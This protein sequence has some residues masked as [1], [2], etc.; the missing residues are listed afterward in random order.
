[1][2]CGASIKPV[3]YGVNLHVYDLAKHGSIGRMV[4]DFT[5]LRA[6]HT[7][8]EVFRHG[9]SKPGIEYSYGPEYGVSEKPPLSNPSM[10]H[11]E[12]I[13]MG[14]CERTPLELTQL[15]FSVRARWKGADYHA[16]NHNCNHFSD[17]LVYILV[18]KHIEARL[19]KENNENKGKQEN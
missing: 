17:D 10:D 1:M 13:F 2:G 15:I 11:R 5:G 18:E 14:T 7:G 9:E 4:G 3:V 16:L 8:V 19:T 6:L 12:T